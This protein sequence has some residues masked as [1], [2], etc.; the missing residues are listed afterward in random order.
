VKR[1]GGSITASWCECRDSHTRRNAAEERVVSA[2]SKKER[3]KL[4]TV[5]GKG[6]EE[7]SR[8]CYLCRGGRGGELEREK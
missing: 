7:L 8:T 4:T 3:K 2:Q 6:I 5:F 1:E